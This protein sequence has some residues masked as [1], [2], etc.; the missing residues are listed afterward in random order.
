MASFDSFGP[1]FEKDTPVLRLNYG[2]DPNA[3]W[4]LWPVF[5]WRV[6]APVPKERKLNLF[7]RA[8]LGLARAKVTAIVDVADRLLIAPDLAG[9][10]VLELQDKALLDHAGEPTAHGL[11]MLDDIEEDPPNEA[12]VGEAEVGEHPGGGAQVLG[13]GGADEDEGRHGRPGAQ[14]VVPS[15]LSSTPFRAT[16]EAAGFTLALASLQSPPVSVK[17]SPSSS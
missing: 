13:E 3:R 15:Q 4:V 9:L 8:V 11:K 7:Q 1:A 12:Q 6:V 16:S 17:P 14:L 10:V 2:K 5:A